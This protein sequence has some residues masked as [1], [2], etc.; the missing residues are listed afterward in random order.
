VVTPPKLDGCVYKGVLYQ[1]GQRWSD[2]CTSTCVCE[3]GK[4]GQYRCSPKCPTFNNLDSRCTLKED[5]NDPCCKF[6]DCPK[7]PNG[8]VVNVVPTYGQG[9]NGY[10]PA[11]APTGT[12]SGTT[13]TSTGGNQLPYNLLNPSGTAAPITGNRQVCVYKGSAH[14]QGEKWQDGCDYNCECKDAST[15]YYQCTDICPDLSNLPSQC[16]LIPD[17]N[18]Q[19]CKTYTCDF[20]KTTVSPNPLGPSGTVA[21][22]VGTTYC[23][24]KGR[25]YRQGEQWNDGC[26]LTCRCED[27][28]NDL[29]SCAN[30]CPQYNNI[31]LGCTRVSDPKDPTC[32]KLPSCSATGTG[33]PGV[34]GGVN[35]VGLSG[36]VTGYARPP[37]RNSVTG[38]R[39]AC[40]YKGVSYNQG[41]TWQDACNFDCECKD[42]S[43][44]KYVCTERC[45]RFGNIPSSCSL[46]PDPN[47]RCCQTVS[48]NPAPPT[49]LT[50]G[51]TVPSGTGTGTGGPGTGTGTG[52]PGTGTG[53]GGTGTGTGTGG[54]TGGTG[55]VTG[56]SGPCTD[57]LKDCYLYGKQSCTGQFKAWAQENCAGFCNFCG[58]SAPPTCQDLIPNCKDYGISSCTGSFQAWAE[59]NCPKFCGI[60]NP[61]P[62]TG[63]GTTPVNTGGGTGQTGGTSGNNPVGQCVDKLTNCNLYPDNNCRAPYEQWALENCP[64][65]CNL[66]SQ[67]TA[68]SGSGNV[69]GTGGTNPGFVTLDPSTN[70]I[71]GSAGSGCYYNGKIYTQGDNWLDGCQYNCTC[72]NGQTGFYRCVER[73]PKY[74]FLPQG[75]SLVTKPGECCATPQCLNADG[76]LT[77]N[78]RTGC[79]YKNVVHQQGDKWDDG[80]DY[81][82][83]CVD[84]KT[85]QYRCTDKCINWQLPSVCSLNQPAPGKCCKTPNCP[86]Y[87]NINYPP[88][89]T[90]E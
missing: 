19:C 56:Y 67:L 57:K 58:T 53:T 70:V 2:G 4:T 54:V 8:Q 35:P 38:F 48:C 10:S 27:A 90:P 13:G 82:C 71:T 89:Y 78:I 11:Q 3:D 74:N 1:E 64:K 52:G 50:G 30:R 80:C 69:G 72:E 60:C 16:V 68:G 79:L 45:Q 28:A 46:V 42:A 26:S 41:V 37:D 84:G 88:N 83:T 24:Y 40:L 17:P 9:T 20:T 81:K 25:Y 65:R 21:P 31:P 6:P 87:V 36:T 34:T 18:N 59:H 32:C 23:T 55:S 85:G 63:S 62:G 12:G 51:A 61:N 86:S 29:H 7:L 43:T 75:C 66:C 22:P 76:S 73:C 39:N 49:P 14:K 44:G 15:G 5:P 77:S 47:D 33:Q